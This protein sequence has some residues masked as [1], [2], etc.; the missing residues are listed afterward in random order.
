MALR[1]AGLRSCLPS[2]FLQQQLT[3]LLAL[4]GSLG[5]LDRTWIDGSR[6]RFV[7]GRSPE[8]TNCSANDTR[9]SRSLTRL[10]AT[11]D[12]KIG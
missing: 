6:P 5:L 4:E 3:F 10:V 11:Y 8:C 9:A 12:L 7:S 1:V 2:L